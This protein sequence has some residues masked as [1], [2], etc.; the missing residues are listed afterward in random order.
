MLFVSCFFCGHSLY[1]AAARFVT[2]SV[3]GHVFEIDFPS[4]YNNWDKVKF[5][6]K[7]VCYSA[8]TK[9]DHVFS[10]LFLGRSGRPF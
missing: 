10:D 5:V 1:Y 6:M 2:T 8:F 9:V 7:C 3:M 4:S